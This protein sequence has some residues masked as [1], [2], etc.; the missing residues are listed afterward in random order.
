MAKETEN[1]LPEIESKRITELKRPPIEVRPPKRKVRMARWL[2]WL[3]VTALVVGAAAAAY[4]LLRGDGE[5]DIRTDLL[6]TRYREAG[7]EL[8][9]TVVVPPTV[10]TTADPTQVPAMALSILDLTPQAQAYLERS[11]ALAEPT[12][13]QA[14]MIAG[15]FVRVNTYAAPTPVPAMALSVIGATP[16]AEAYLE[17]AISMALPTESQASIISPGEVYVPASVYTSAAETLVPAMALSVIGATPGAEAYLVRSIAPAE[18]TAWQ[19]SMITPPEPAAFVVPASVYTSAEPT[20]VPAMALSVIGATPGA[21]AYL[22]RSIAPAAPTASQAALMSPFDTTPWQTRMITTAVPEPGAVVVPRSVYTSAAPTLVPAM[23]LS[24]L[25][26]TPQ[27]E[28]YLARSI[29][30]AAPTVSQAAL[31]TRPEKTY[32][33]H[34]E[35]MRPVAGQAGG[36]L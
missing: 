18:P 3:V 17:R 28:A 4:F 6:A 26:A 15:P 1:R 34:G 32:P 35:T 16:G 13:W 24:I 23:A 31:I 19:A 2:E 36:P 5:A 8:P 12:A 22:A 33:D 30:P 14:S 21:E 20:L 29:D 27:A 11:V 25:N 9:A 10:Y 7:V